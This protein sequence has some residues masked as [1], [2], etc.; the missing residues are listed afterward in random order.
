[1]SNAHDLFYVFGSELDKDGVGVHCAC[2][3]MHGKGYNQYNSCLISGLSCMNVPSKMF[4]EG[5]FFFRL[6]WRRTC[7]EKFYKKML[8][9]IESNTNTLLSHI[10]SRYIIYMSYLSPTYICVKKKIKSNSSSLN[11][12][13]HIRNI[14]LLFV[15]LFFFPFIIRKVLVLIWNSS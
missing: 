10:N 3:N 7:K 9:L 8:Q 2:M 12:K 4:D 11:M 5:N 1:M 6:K 15:H 13:L 14:S